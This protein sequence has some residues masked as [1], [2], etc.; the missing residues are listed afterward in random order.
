MHPKRPLTPNFIHGSFQFFG[1]DVTSTFGA[2]S[3]PLTLPHGARITAIE[4]VVRD[5]SAT[6]DIFISLQRSTFDA[7]TNT[8]PSSVSLAAVQTTDSSGLQ[9]L[10]ATLAVPETVRHRD[11]NLRNIYLLF[12]VIQDVVANVGLRDCTITWNRQVSP[13]PAVA[14]FA[15]VPV[16]HPQRAFVEALAAAGITGGCGGGNFCP[17]AALTRGQMAVFLAAAL[18]LHFPN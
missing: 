8:T 16:G 18:G 3:C 2:V 9:T 11:G 14:T 13:P 7:S 4:C 10:S 5:S 15:D 1:N 6:G 12:V 17:D